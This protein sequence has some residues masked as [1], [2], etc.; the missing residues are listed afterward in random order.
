MQTLYVGNTLINDAFLGDKRIADVATY[1]DKDAT[2]FI[3]ATGIT[4][5]AVSAVSYLVQKLK[6]DNLWNKMYAIYPFVGANST[7]NRYN[8]KDTGSFLL[9]FTGS[10]TYSSNGVQGNIT[11]THIDTSLATNAAGISDWDTSASL[12]VYATNNTSNGY[13]IGNNTNYLITRY[14]NNVA[15][16]ANNGNITTASLDSK[17]FLLGVTSGSGASSSRMFKNGTQVQTGNLTGGTGGNLYIGANNAG[18]VTDRSDRNYAFTSIGGALST[19]DASNL[20]TIVQ[21]FETI[22]GRQV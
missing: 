14:F 9:A 7:S 2:N 21:N 19:T 13:D 10:W 22:L 3:V 17:G 16:Y 15:Y 6:A 5:S 12:S 4:G 11:D 20:Y 8:L 18:T 1:V